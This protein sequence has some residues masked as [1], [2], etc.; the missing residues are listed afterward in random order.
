MSTTKNQTPN[1]LGQ[2][3]P[4]PGTGVQGGPPDQDTPVQVNLSRNSLAALG[5]A[6][7]ME[8][9][10]WNQTKAKVEQARAALDETIKAEG[11]ARQAV[12]QAKGRFNAAQAD[13]AGQG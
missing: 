6:V 10:K 8:T 5:A 9:R 4:P 2:G 11:A 1:T 7:E 12:E 3:F 13:L